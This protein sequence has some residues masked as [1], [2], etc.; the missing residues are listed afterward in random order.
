[1][2]SHTVCLTFF[3]ECWFCPFVYVKL[4]VRKKKKNKKSGVIGRHC[5]SQR[6]TSLYFPTA[7]P[8]GQSWL[9]YPLMSLKSSYRSG[10]IATLTHAIC[11][12]LGFCVWAHT[13]S[14]SHSF[15]CMVTRQA[16]SVNTWPRDAT[17]VS[18][19]LHIW[20]A[21]P[22]WLFRCAHGALIKTA[23]ICLYT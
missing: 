18:F 4:T 14:P 16:F 7:L 20:F 19:S 1:M 3:E 5:E 2:N 13:A 12:F 23:F 22:F 15:T 6:N 9:F 10:R 21:D 11:F 8:D 17:R